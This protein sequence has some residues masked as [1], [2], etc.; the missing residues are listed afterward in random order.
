MVVSGVMTWTIY[1]QTALLGK[2]AVAHDGRFTRSNRATR[3]KTI[4]RDLD[5]LHELS[6]LVY[7]EE[8]CGRR[9][10]SRAR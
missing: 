9:R 7:I 10:A 8:E 4:R 5:I 2:Q 3:P 1:R 6:P